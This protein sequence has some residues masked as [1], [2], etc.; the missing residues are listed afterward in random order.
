MRLRP[1][2]RDQ[3]A[4]VQPPKLR[5][6]ARRPRDAVEV[7]LFGP[8][9]DHQEQ[10]ALPLRLGR[11]ADDQVVEDPAVLVQQQGVAELAGGE[12]ADVAADQ[13]L[14][15]GRDGGV[16]RLGIAAAPGQG[17]HR[18]PHVRDV[19]QAGV[20]AGPGVLLEDALRI[21]DRHVV[22]AEA[23]RPRAQ[24]LVGGMQHRGLCGRGG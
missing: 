7:G 10:F 12:A 24:R 16:V 4:I 21:L 23:D 15:Q 19:E 20:L 6:A 8:G 11:A 2:Q 22:A 18:R 5:L 9:V 14:D 13:R 3:A 1:L 17:Q